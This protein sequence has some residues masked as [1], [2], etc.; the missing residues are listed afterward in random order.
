MTGHYGMPGPGGSMGRCA[1]CGDTFIG[2]VVLDM[3]GM[4]NGIVSFSVGFIEQTLYCHAPKCKDILKVA[5]TAGVDGDSAAV[6]E[7]LPD[8]PL[9]E[10]MA[11]AL[12]QQTEK[13]D[14]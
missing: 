13:A 14:D 2:G 8:G 12:A 3:M 1:V 6:M 10:A 7:E 4:D 9:K 11:K 5:F